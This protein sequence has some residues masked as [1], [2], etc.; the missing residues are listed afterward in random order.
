MISVTAIT[1]IIFLPATRFSCW[2]KPSIF[3]LQWSCKGGCRCGQPAGG[4]KDAGSYWFSF[5]T[6]LLT[7]VILCWIESGL[8]RKQLAT[9]RRTWST[10]RVL[11]RQIKCREKVIKS[12]IVFFCFLDTLNNVSVLSVK[13]KQKLSSY[14]LIYTFNPSI[15]KNN[16]KPGGALSLQTVPSI[17]YSLTSICAFLWCGE[18]GIMS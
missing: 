18:N 13:T 17:P 5:V 4:R 14:L 8:H 2:T 7:A 10:G 11:F 16:L 9:V 3:K 6:I 12:I 15:H 1:T